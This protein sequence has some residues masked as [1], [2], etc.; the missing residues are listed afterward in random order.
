MAEME[1]SVEQILA[2][3]FILVADQAHQLPG[4]MQCEGARAPRQSNPGFFR[5]AVSLAVVALVAASDQILPGRPS[6][7]RSR[8]DVIQG[9]LR[10]RKRAAAE[11]AGVTVAQ[12]DVLP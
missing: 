8:D 1:G 12:Q 3:L 2:P 11:L 7:A 10:G 9:Q 4:G 5:S 6:A